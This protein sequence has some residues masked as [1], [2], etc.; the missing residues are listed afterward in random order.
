MR[1]IINDQVVLSRP[2]EVSARSCHY[3]RMSAKRLLRI[4]AGGDP[5]AHAD[6]YSYVIKPR[7]AASRV[8]RALDRSCDIRCSAPV[9]MRRRTEHTSF[10]MD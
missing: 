1:Y 6:A 2:L 5:K 4:C 7:S 3:R 9:L 8:P 10:V